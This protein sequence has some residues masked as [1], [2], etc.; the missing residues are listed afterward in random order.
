MEHTHLPYSQPEAVKTVESWEGFLGRPQTT[1]M[2]ASPRPWLKLIHV[3][4]SNHKEYSL[5]APKEEELP[6]CEQLAGF[7]HRVD[8]SS[9][10]AQVL[11]LK[12]L[13]PA[14]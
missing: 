12:L 11:R 1:D 9:L 6:V 8:I 4:P 5:C 13:L 10:T 7:C 14:E 2:T 3:A